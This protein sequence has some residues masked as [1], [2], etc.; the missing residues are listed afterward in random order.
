M[1]R[2][3]PCVGVHE[4]VLEVLGA[5]EESLGAALTP[6]RLLV[7]SVND[8]TALTAADHEPVL[9]GSKRRGW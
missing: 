2:R 8:V 6:I 7:A 3:R 1:Q 5:K 9:A 4:Q